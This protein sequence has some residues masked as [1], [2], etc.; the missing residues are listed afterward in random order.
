MSDSKIQTGEMQTIAL[1]AADT[2]MATPTDASQMLATET[3]WVQTRV[4]L[5]IIFILLAVAG[6]LWLI[7]ALEGVL[8]L[9]VLAIFFA[10]LIAPL[11]NL[12]R[13]PFKLRGGEYTMPRAIAIA[14]VYLIIFGTIG[15]AGYVIVPRISAQ[16]SDFT[17]NS[18][19]YAG[20]IQGRTDRLRQITQ[21]IGIPPAFQDA[22]VN[23]IKNVVESAKKSI[24][25]GDAN[26]TALGVVSFI[27]WLVLIPIL[28]FFLLKD[29]DDFRRSALQMLPRGRLRWR[30]DEFFQDVN[31][32]L[33]AYIRAQLIACM[34]IGF[35]CTIAFWIIGVPYW[36]ALGILAGV[37]EFIPLA[38]PLTVAVI[39][40]IVASF[41]STGQAAAVLAFLV[42][43][44]IVNDYVIY[45]RIIGSGIHLH[46]LAIVLAILCG[47]TLAGLAGI[48]LAIPVVAI[49]SV[50]YRHWLEHRGSQGIVADLLKPVEQSVVNVAMPD[51]TS[52][53]GIAALP[54]GAN[55]IQP[56]TPGVQPTDTLVAR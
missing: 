6:V 2:A 24:E 27:P 16:I 40:T 55:D 15:V 21:R 48:F 22:A 12:V 50:M 20:L 9:V 5:R 38:G 32:T 25:E 3:T 14:I 8:L 42:V 49:V 43:L 11:V 30:G 53:A 37:L 28:A 39:A 31:S 51:E 19:T 54:S 34:L 23:S 56:S 41:S 46:P 33:A 26:D 18:S 47:E 17:R 7:Y 4:V 52:P 36:L 44:R 45:P 13:R 10:Y 35:V 1:T 29:A